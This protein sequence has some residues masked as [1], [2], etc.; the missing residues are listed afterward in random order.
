MA[1]FM[2]SWFQRKL[3]GLRCLQVFTWKKKAIE[4]YTNI[5]I[6]TL[7]FNKILKVSDF[8]SIV[9]KLFEAARNFTKEVDAF[10][11]MQMNVIKSK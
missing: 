2:N 3:L 11:T 9:D 8:F 7:G 1:H 4:P 10:Y 5:C 6:F